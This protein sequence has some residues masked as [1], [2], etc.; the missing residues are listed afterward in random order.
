MPE[1][2]GD[3]SFQITFL[4][5]IKPGAGTNW[6]RRKLNLTR[7]KRRLPNPIGL[8]LLFSGISALAVSI[9]SESTILAFIGLGLTFW[10]ALLIYLK[11]EIYIKSKLLDSTVLS[12]LENL[13]KIIT[14]LDIKGKAIYLPPEYLKDFKSGIAY[15][16]KKKELEIPSV[17]EV[18]EAKTFSKNPHGIFLTPPGLSLTNLFE[19]ELGTDF[20]RADLPTLQK[21]MPKLFI[22]NLEIAQDLQIEKQGN[23]V[24]VKITDSIY[25]D[26]CIEARKLQNICGQIGCPISSAIACALA[27][28]TGKPVTIEKDET[29]EDN[30]ITTIQY[31]ILED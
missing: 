2:P 22:E 8:I 7:F 25:K 1:I 30:N 10:G 24:N 3:S 6:Q 4:R 9:L 29:S 19:K 16:S 14:E 21:D 26:F 23:I 11:N 28:A 13:D 20:V 18:S 15:I 5:R 27:R 17:D 12:S 31:K